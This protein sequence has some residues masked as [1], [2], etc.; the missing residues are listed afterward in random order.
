[1]GTVPMVEG[2]GGM[3]VEEIL[4]QL[5]RRAMRDPAFRAALLATAEDRNP[6]S[7]L[8]AFSTAAGL[9]LYEMD[10]LTAGEERYAA[11]RRSTNGG[12]ENSPLLAGEDDTYELFMTEL[13][14]LE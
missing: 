13:R 5:K 9:P 12:G 14:K 1:M 8:C 11:M 7:A 4:E 6:L 10:L 3:E 2:R